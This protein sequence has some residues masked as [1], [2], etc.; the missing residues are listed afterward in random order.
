MKLFFVFIVLV[1]LVQMGLVWATRT[2]ASD[3]WPTELAVYNPFWGAGIVALGL[4]GIACVTF[5]G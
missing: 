4:I 3:S 5:A 2:S 1:G